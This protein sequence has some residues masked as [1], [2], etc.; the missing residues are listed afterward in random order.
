M[1]VTVCGIPCEAVVLDFAVEPCG[2]I[3]LEYVLNIKGSRAKWLEA[4]LAV[5]PKEEARLFNEISE[6]YRY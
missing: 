1:N 6:R 2:Y 5:S 3:H 4:K